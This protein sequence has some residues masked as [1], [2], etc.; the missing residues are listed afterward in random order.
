MT[1]EFLL[2]AI[3]KFSAELLFPLLG[4]VVNIFAT[5]RNRNERHSI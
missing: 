1:F 2:A 3:R 5:A 4:P